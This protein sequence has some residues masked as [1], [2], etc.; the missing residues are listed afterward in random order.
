MICR[1]IRDREAP[2]SNPGPPTIPNSHSTTPQT[3]KS[4]RSVSVVS[5]LERAEA[6]QAVDSLQ[7]VLPSVFQL[8]P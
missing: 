6:N 1:A 7:G 2:G 8:Q 3:A 4:G 5:E